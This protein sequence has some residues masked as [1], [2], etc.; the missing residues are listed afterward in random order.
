MDSAKARALN[1]GDQTRQEPHGPRQERQQAPRHHRR[2]GHALGCHLDRGQSQRCEGQLPE[3]LFQTGKQCSVYSGFEIACTTR[4]WLPRSQVALRNALV[5]EVSLRPPEA[6]AVQLPGQVCSQGQLGN[7][8]KAGRYDH[9]HAGTPWSAS[10][11]ECLQPG[12]RKP[13][14]A[15]RGRGHRHHVGP[16]RSLALVLQNP[17]LPAIWHQ[18]HIF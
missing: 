1:G 3:S 11:L 9:S 15:L 13:P 17:H 12:N 2:Q 16:S 8:E 14:A 7:E 6:E 10:F 18:S 4:W 5:C